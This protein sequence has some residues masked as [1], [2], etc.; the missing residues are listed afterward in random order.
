MK[1]LR[2]ILV[3]ALAVA[4]SSCDLLGQGT[5]QPSLA[6]L[7]ATAMAQAQAEIAQTAA[8]QPTALPTDAPTDTPALTDTPTAMAI[9]TP[10]I[11]TTPIPTIATVASVSSGAAAASSAKT[12]YCNTT[13]ISTMKGP[14]VNVDFT[15]NK[16]G[17]FINLYF[18]IT[19]TAFGCGYGNIQMSGGDSTTISMPQ[20]CYFFYGWIDGPHQ[21]TTQGNACFSRGD[22]QPDHMIITPSTVYETG[23]N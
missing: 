7:Q 2:F 1:Y 23:V 18:Y 20:G 15:S 16:V 19:E 11:P 22:I 4:L 8:A 9:N 17:G 21:S 12:D 13:S 3:F 6:S 10:V 14:H 5:P